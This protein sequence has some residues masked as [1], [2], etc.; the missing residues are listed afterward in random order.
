[1]TI[2]ANVQTV[3]PDVLTDYLCTL[4]ESE[5]SFLDAA[6]LE[7]KLEIGELGGRNIQ[8]ITLWGKDHMVYGFPP[9]QCKLLVMMARGRYKLYLADA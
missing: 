9:V 1:M 5:T 7:C 6:L 8:R 2:A 3:L 4:I